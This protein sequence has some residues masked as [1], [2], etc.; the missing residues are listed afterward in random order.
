M[1]K[2][3]F[4][5]PESH[6]ESVKQAVFD[7]GAG[8][9]GGYDQCSW[10]TLGAGQYRPL[11]GASPFLGEVGELELVTEYKVEMVCEE[12]YIARALDALKLAHP[13]ETPAFEVYPLLDYSS[14]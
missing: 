3:C 7:A 2:L 6:M 11:A 1:L 4:F 12:R 8:R 13:Y 14:S 9:I 10:Q 5:V